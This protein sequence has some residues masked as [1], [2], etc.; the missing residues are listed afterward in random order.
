MLRLLGSF[1]VVIIG[2]VLGIVGTSKEPSKLKPI[3]LGTL[4]FVSGC[5]LFPLSNYVAAALYLV[6]GL[7]LF[8]AGLTTKQ[9]GMTSGD[10][11]KLMWTMISIVLVVVM[12]GY[13]MLKDSS[14]K[15]TKTTEDTETT[16]DDN[17]G[18]WKIKYFVDDFGEPT[19]EGYIATTIAGTFSNNLTQ[20]SKLGV[21]F[22]IGSS[23]II[24]IKIY[25]YDGDNPKILQSETSYKVLVKDSEEEV[26]TLKA[27]HD[28][29]RLSFSNAESKKLY[30]IL[31]KGGTIKFNIVASNKFESRATEYNFTIDN[32][33][34]FDN[35]FNQL[36]NSNN[37]QKDNNV[38]TNN[39]ITSTSIAGV[40][41]IGK[42]VK[43]IKPHFDTDYL[44]EYIEGDEDRLPVYMVKKE[45]TTIIEFY[46]DKN[47]IFSVCILDPT[48]ETADGLHVG[49]TSG[50]ILK[51]Y[52]KAIVYSS[53]YNGESSEINGITYFYADEP[54][55]DID[56]EFGEGAIL[57]KNVKI[58]SIGIRGNR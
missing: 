48:F 38:Q 28:Y 50:D 30:N 40:E 25:E 27:Y 35:A 47:K 37:A 32:A 58:T 55:S 33:D 53:E 39:L 31:L 29:D 26:H 19:K 12:G 46:I 11:K 45:K 14:E 4:T 21:V 49:S 9:V 5:A 17:L 1:V 51:K 22:I 52:P 2:G 34:G 56:E 16:E 43:E 41:V 3:I 42:T 36:T 44:W 8:L 23:E 54:V 10:R 15:Q 6:A 24:D 57:N 18:I 13:F 7:L 20:N